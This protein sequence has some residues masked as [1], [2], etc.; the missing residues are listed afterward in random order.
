MSDSH[1]NNNTNLCIIFVSR[2][3]CSPALDRL[4][5]KHELHCDNLDGQQ[6]A[7]AFIKQAVHDVMQSERAHIYP[8]GIRIRF[9]NWRPSP[10]DDQMDTLYGVSGDEQALSEAR[11]DSLLSDLAWRS[12]RRFA[13]R[14]GGHPL[15]SSRGVILVR[16]EFQP[17]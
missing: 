3:G 4:L 12:L 13:D 15:G 10:Q 6:S 5:Q 7:E 9:G 14:A 16:V 11:T 2:D 8:V 17:I 1:N